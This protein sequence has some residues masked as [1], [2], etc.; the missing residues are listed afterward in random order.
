MTTTSNS[1]TNTSLTIEST[2]NKYVSRVALGADYTMNSDILKYILSDGG[3]IPPGSGNNLGGVFPTPDDVNN[4]LASYP[5]YQLQAKHR[6]TWVGGNDVVN[7]YYQFCENDDVIHPINATDNF[8]M[9]RVYNEAFDENQQILYLSFGLPDFT[10][11]S[12]FIKNA[13]NSDLA[14]LMNTGEVSAAAEV[15]NFIGKVVGTIIMIPIYPIKI[16]WWCLTASLAS[17]PTKYYDF[18]PSMGLYY[19]VVNVMLATV[20]ANMNLTDAI[21]PNTNLPASGVTPNGDTL[22]GIPELFKRHGLDI[23]SILSRKRQY[24]NADEPI[25]NNDTFFKNSISDSKFELSA[26]SAFTA[27]GT[28]SLTEEMRYFGLRI[29]KSTASQESA[30]NSTKEPDFLAV[31]NGA[32]SAGRETN[33]ITNAIKNIG[34]IAGGAISSVTDFFSSMATGVAGSLDLTGGVEMLMGAGFLDVPE[35]WNSSQFN[36]S[37]NFDFQLRSPYGDPISI[38]YSLYIPLI[39]LICG[40]FPRS[41]GQNA[42]TSPFLVRAYCQGMFSVP[43]GIIDSISIKRGNAEYGWANASGAMLPTEIDVS[44][45]I[46]DLSPVMH[47]AIADGS[48]AENIKAWF[49]ILGQNSTFQEYMLTLSGVNIAQRTLLFQQFKKRSTALM[50]IASNNR[51]NPMMFGFSLGNSK[52]GSMLSRIMPISRLPGRTSSTSST[53]KTH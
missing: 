30:S 35:I 12:D 43:L 52:L 53:A 2:E 51:F 13:Y 4:I 8:G 18:K 25:T 37:Y 39:M 26:W 42:Y 22:P 48:I 31:V 21:D 28:A 45:T 49:S 7:S 38:F 14:R 36:K 34:G 20:A 46:K 24:D 9:G 6:D 3:T 47:L 17:T 40:A 19:K 15:G 41:V 11:A 33:N 32:V 27:G 50:T 29:E 23:L 10:N 44:M 1:I 16:G 5:A